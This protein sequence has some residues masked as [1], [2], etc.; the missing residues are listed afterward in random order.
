MLPLSKDKKYLLLGPAANCLSALNGCWSYSWQGDR[1]EVYP[2]NGRTILDV[3][4]QRFKPDQIFC[5]V[6]N[7][8]TN[9]QN[10]EI[11]FSDNDIKDIDFVLLFLGE[12]AYAES[13]G[14]IND[15]TL[16]ENQIILAKKARAYLDKNPKC[17]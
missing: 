6:D 13:P 16:D 5:N 7:N 11:S 3:F 12:N 17:K 15:L 8:Y 2:E 1:E 10:F 4:K 14:N 9:S